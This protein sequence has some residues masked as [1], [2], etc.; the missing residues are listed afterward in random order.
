MSQD[1]L[2]LWAIVLNHYLWNENV[3]HVICLSLHGHW[4]PGEEGGDSP[5]FRMGVCC[6]MTGNLTL[7]QTKRHNFVPLFQTKWWK[8]I[9]CS[10]LKN[11]RRSWPSNQKQ[12]VWVN[13][14]WDLSGNSN[15]VHL[16]CNSGVENCFRDRM[17]KSILCSREKRWFV[18]PVP[19]SE[20]KTIPCWA[21]HPR[22]AHIWEYPP[23]PIYGST[24]PP[25][26]LG[27]Q[28]NKQTNKQVLA[29]I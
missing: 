16:Q 9:P 24:P 11:V 18:D 3:S 23:P 29:V 28:T 20:V 2:L 25:L 10:R 7:L 27:H 26:G 15:S 1:G 8:L 5:Q 12:G 17:A 13:M 19:D 21:A 6:W 4:V 14:Q 22:I